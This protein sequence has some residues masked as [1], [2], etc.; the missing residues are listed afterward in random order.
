MEKLLLALCL[1]FVSCGNNKKTESTTQETSQPVTETKAA[2]EPKT[3]VAGD[4][5]T[6][7][8]K[9]GGE[10]KFLFKEINTIKLADGTYNLVLKVQIKNNLTQQL[11]ISD[12]SWKLTDTDMIEVEESGVYDSEFEMFKP[13]MFFFTTVDAGFGKVE[14]VGYKVNK[15]TYYLNIWGYT[16]AKIEIRD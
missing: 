15:G 8:S 6:F 1:L 14:E 5:L 3:L 4:E 2:K 7:P 16:S 13:A 11:L 9:N 12:V 10:V